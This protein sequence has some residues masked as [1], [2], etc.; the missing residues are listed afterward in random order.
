MKH[1]FIFGALIMILFV[2]ASHALASPKLNITTVKIPWFDSTIQIKNDT[3]YVLNFWATWCIPCVAELPIFE[4]IQKKYANG[5]VRIILISL[6]YVKK[7]ETLL[8]PF[9]QRKK[10]SLPVILLDEPDANKWI[11]KVDSTWSGAI[12]ATLIVNNQ[13]GFRTFLEKELNF[14]F[15]D[16]VVKLSLHPANK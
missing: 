1:N 7:I 3:T 11:N 6:D 2:N 10:I 5:P 16:S 13:K 8:K 9:L 15:L 12:P 4:S 14:D